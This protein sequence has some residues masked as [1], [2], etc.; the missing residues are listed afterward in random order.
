MYGQ[1]HK[2]KQKVKAIHKKNLERTVKDNGN[3]LSKKVMLAAL[4]KM[5]DLNHMNLSLFAPSCVLAFF[6]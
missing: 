4:K 1:I 2:R 5:V 6:E 3:L